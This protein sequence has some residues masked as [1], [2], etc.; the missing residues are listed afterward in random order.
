MSDLYLKKDVILNKGVINEGVLAYIALRK[1][2]PYETV[3]TDYIS[4]KRMA[5]EL[6]GV[7]DNY[8]DALCKSLSTGLYVLNALDI[9][10]IVSKLDKDNM[11]FIIDASNLVFDTHK[12][13]WTQIDSDDIAKI[14]NG[15]SRN[16]SML[17]VIRYF[18]T[19]VSSFNHSKSM[20]EYQGRIGGMTIDVLADDADISTRSAKRYN[21]ILMDLKLI[22]IHKADDYVREGDEIKRI[23]NTY[24]RYCDMDKC[25]TY[26]TNKVEMF[27]FEHKVIR[28]KKKAETANTNRKLAQ[29]Y[30][31]LCNETGNYS[32]DEIRKIYNYCNNMNE[33]L[34][35]EIDTKENAT[36]KLSF[37]EEGYLT[38]LKNRVRDM[39]IF[40]QYDFLTDEN[41]SD[42]I[43]IFGN[44]DI[45]GEVDNTAM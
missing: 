29:E 40:E 14:I 35:R 2:F 4:V 7:A 26:G 3:T 44:N 31:F 10:K 21:D 34:Q 5:Y 41:K 18:I 38:K 23:N 17:Q 24:S 33:S 15:V 43:P 22:Y 30:N 8:K 19:M 9:I 27:G 32:D 28:A 6:C 1:I 16:D 42:D 13:F 12:C 37:S 36:Y 45:W 11:E 25:I 20:G 39:T